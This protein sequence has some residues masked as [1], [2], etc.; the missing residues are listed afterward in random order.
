[1]ARRAALAG[2]LWLVL[3]VL[4]GGEGGPNSAHQASPADA[5]QQATV[6]GNASTAQGV[7][8]PVAKL[9]MVMLSAA[10]DAALLSAA[11]SNEGW[12][13]P[14]QATQTP[15]PAVAVWTAGVAFGCSADALRRWHLEDAPLLTSWQACLQRAG[16]P[17]LPAPLPLD[18]AQRTAAASTAQLCAGSAS[19]QKHHSEPALPGLASLVLARLEA[20]ASFL[21]KPQRSAVQPCTVVVGAGPVGTA[22]AF[23]ALRSGA[24]V[25]LVE[26]RSAYTRDTWFDIMPPP[27]YTSAHWLAPLRPNLSSMHVQWQGRLPF[28]PSA[29][30]HWSGPRSEAQ[31]MTVRCH[32]LETWLAALLA[33]ASAAEWPVQLLAP[34]TVT[35]VCADRSELQLRPGRHRSVT[36]APGPCS[37]TMPGSLSL[38]FS[39]LVLATGA[40]SPLPRALGLSTRQV[41]EVTLPHLQRPLHVAGLQ[42]VTLILHFQPVPQP[43]GSL[44]CPELAAGVDPWSIAFEAP[45]D[46]TAVFRR[47]YLPQA[48]HM[49]VLLGHSAGQAALAMYTEAAARARSSAS[50]SAATVGG[51]GQVVQLHTSVGG[52]TAPGPAHAHWQWHALPWPTLLR[53]ARHY[54]A[55]P[56]LHT[57]AGLWAGLCGA[58]G[59]G[60]RGRVVPVR[61]TAANHTVS[62]HAGSPVFLVG[63]AAVSAHYRLGIGVNSGV[64]SMPWLTAALR[65]LRPAVA[66]AVQEWDAA[67]MQRVQNM[68][69]LQSSVVFME[70]YCGLV[71]FWDWSAPS[72]WQAPR[73]HRPVWSSG[74]YEPVQHSDSALQA[75][76]ARYM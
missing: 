10:D 38:P 19:Q 73:W 65:S 12:P 24:C 72:L 58:P 67:G 31:V 18:A 52:C 3:S 25:R 43:D 69:A 22:A 75:C 76:L 63:D 74:D 50:G 14:H 36:S 51:Q 13:K 29:W 62:T 41:E 45:H 56:A 48:C 60:V 59:G 27:W 46:A 70:A 26:Q 6:E 16:L 64:G 33:I 35:E 34:Y 53:V 44:A 15:E 54:L 37:Q 40:A 21:G 32:E 47:W 9:H 39:A 1:M 17:P 55:D 2:P 23:A 5:W 20:L 8:S 66:P 61:I 71:L 30:Q 68:S 57:E 4:I 11:T 49:Q 28:E 7:C 42:Q